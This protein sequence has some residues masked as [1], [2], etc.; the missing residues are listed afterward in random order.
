[1]LFVYHVKSL[2][3][4]RILELVPYSYMAAVVILKTINLTKILLDIAA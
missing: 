4:I 1:M 2:W 3:S